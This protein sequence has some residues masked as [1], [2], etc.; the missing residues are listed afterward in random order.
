MRILVSY[1]IESNYKRTK[2]AKFLKTYLTRV[3]KSVFEGEIEEWNL[4]KIRS[5]LKEKI[6][7]ETDSVRIYRLCLKCINSVDVLGVAT[8]IEPDEDIVV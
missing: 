2:V 1:D 3:Q 8:Y 6:N 5:A 4:E 7:L